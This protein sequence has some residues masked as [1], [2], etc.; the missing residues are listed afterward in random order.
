MSQAIIPLGAESPSKAMHQ[1]ATI[2]ALHDARVNLERAST[3]LIAL[4]AE[5][6]THERGHALHAALEFNSDAEKLTGWI[7]RHQTWLED[8]P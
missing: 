6:E 5:Q 7:R 3:A 8:R 4:A 1:R 2:L